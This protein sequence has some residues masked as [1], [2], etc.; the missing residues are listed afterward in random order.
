MADPKL[1][2]HREEFQVKNRE[3]GFKS[4]S[5]EC[6]LK[7]ASINFILMNDKLKARGKK[8]VE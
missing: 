3:R 6:W 4:Q 5:T 2:L 8:P 1:A 7:I